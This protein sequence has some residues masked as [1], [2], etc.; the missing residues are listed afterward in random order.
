MELDTLSNDQM[1]TELAR[2]EVLRTRVASLQVALIAEADRRQLP[3]WDGCRTLAD[4]VAWRL[5]VS[6]ATARA[7]VELARRLDGLPELAKR[8][9]EGAVGLE[10]TAAIAPIA[11]ATTERALVDRLEGSD[12]QG[13]RRFAARHRRL[14]PSQERHAHEASYVVIQP[15]LD[16]SWWRVWGGLAGSAGAV[17]EEALKQRAD[18]LPQDGTASTHRQA[19]ALES[20]ALDSLDAPLPDGTVARAPSVTAFVDWELASRTQGEAGAEVAIG[21]RIGPDTLEELWCEGTVRLVGIRNGQPVTTTSAPSTIPPA[22]RDYVLWR[23]GACRAPGCASRHRLQPHH[24]VPRSHG[25]GHRPDNL[26]TLC[27]YHHHVVVHR[28]GY[29]IEAGP[30]RTIRFV[31]PADSRDPP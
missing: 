18:Q 5:D 24:I 6:P 15:S 7:Y 4:W 14:A 13:V 12:L 3:T 29:R 9:S 8:F 21:P 20:L 22:V 28:R 11:T 30:D 2:L 25:G 17:V 16:E 27:W 10:R 23:D 31:V 1:E 26:V 19:L